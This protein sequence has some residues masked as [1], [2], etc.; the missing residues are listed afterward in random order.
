MMSCLSGCGKVHSEIVVKP[1]CPP[2]FDYTEKTRLDAANEL[3]NLGEDSAL[4]RMMKDYVATRDAARA[5]HVF[6]IE[7]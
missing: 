2:I 5:C 6:L 7:K 3:N 4:A 1:I